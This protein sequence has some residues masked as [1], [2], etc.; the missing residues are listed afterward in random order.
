MYCLLRYFIQYLIP[1]QTGVQM[2]LQSK[3]KL[4]RPISAASI[5]SPWNH[6]I[7]RNSYRLKECQEVVL[8]FYYHINLEPKRTGHS[9]TNSTIYLGSDP[10]LR[11][12][13]PLQHLDQAFQTPLTWSSVRYVQKPNILF[14]TLV[15]QMTPANDEVASSK[16]PFLDIFFLPMT[17]K[18]SSP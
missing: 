12:E 8:L 14:L 5:V 13:K 15:N 11:F 6:S 16:S 18:S 3:E 7:Q 2:W 4:Q 10:V 17:H 9:Q 1:Q